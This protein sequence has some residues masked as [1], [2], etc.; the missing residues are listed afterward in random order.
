MKYYATD[1][2]K[3][4]LL[5]RNISQ[6]DVTECLKNHHTEYPVKGNEHCRWYVGSV[7]KR[8][9]RV[10]VDNKKSTLVTAYWLNE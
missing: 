7:G 5:Q 8:K 6:K 4:R 3:E 10:M 9:L 1:H 2:L